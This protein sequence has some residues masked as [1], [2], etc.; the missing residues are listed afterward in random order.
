MALEQH[1]RFLEMALEQA[2]LAGSEGTYPIGAVLVGP[3]GEVIATGRN[4]V[5]SQQ[6]ASAHA[7]ID[8]IRQAG[9][10]LH[11]PAYRHRCTLYTSVEPCLMCTGAIIYADID[12]VVWAMSDH[13]GGALALLHKAPPIWPHKFDRI[14]YLA[15]PFPDLEQRQREL[16]VAWEEGRGRDGKIWLQV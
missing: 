9:G 3:D 10:L 2:A 7:E 15:A 8:V 11:Q 6:D 1:R 16:K 14:R 13:I 12:Q 5:F 4:R